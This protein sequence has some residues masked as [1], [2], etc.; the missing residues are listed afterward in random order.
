MVRVGLD[1]TGRD[2]TTKP[3][4]KRFDNQMTP[5]RF[6][7]RLLAGLLLTLSGLAV[8]NGLLDHSRL[9]GAPDIEGI[10]SFK[11]Y[12][13]AGQFVSKPYTVRRAQPDAIILGTSRAGASLR[14]GHEAWAGF[15]PYNFALAGS[16]A[17]IQWW[18]FRH[19]VKV[20]Q[21]QRA[22]LALDFMMFNSCREQGSEPHFRE[23]RQ[24]LA[25]TETN[26]RYPVRYLVDHLGQLT[27]VQSTRLS[28]LTWR[29]QASF[30]EPESGN[31]NLH[32]DGYWERFP[33]PQESQHQGFKVTE[34]N[35]LRETWF[36]QPQSCYSLVRDGS[37]VQLDHLR[38]LLYLAHHNNVELHVYFSPF[39]A[40][41]AE[42]MVAAGLW[43]VFEELKTDVVALNET[44]AT[45]LGLEP[46]PL[47]DFS[48][49]NA[50]NSE[51]IPAPGDSSTR[52]KYY[53]DGTHSTSLTGDLVQDVLFDT[54]VAKGGG[55]PGFGHQL[56]G[57]TLSNVLEHIRAEQTR[58]RSQHA[59]QFRELLA[60]AGR[61][62][63]G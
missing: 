31:L 63:R 39:H 11:P 55:V 38:K 60:M 17:E 5:Q 43:T 4:Q 42:L 33:A 2:F 18:N 34:R 47:W 12:F 58:Y 54:N 37:K 62:G 44:I 25:G 19:A 15:R 7:L 6:F 50:V 22:V 1:Y 45:E 32:R 57:G 52:M 23:Y 24:R 20:S 21:I 49:Y 13:F 9:F 10:N 35:Y 30:S 46:F 40:R 8:F 26:W 59:E 51:Q 16:T 48:G 36:P 61:F 14:T 56:T 3:S 29:T 27:S 28:W 53:V 41:F